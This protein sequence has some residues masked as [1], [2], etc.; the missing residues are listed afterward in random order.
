MAAGA[1]GT[2]DTVEPLPP[3][4]GYGDYSDASYFDLD[5]YA[6]THQTARCPLDAG[7][8][9]ELLPPGDGIAFLDTDPDRLGLAQE[10][11]AACRAGLNLSSQAP[12]TSEQAAIV[13]AYQL[14]CLRRPGK[15]RRSA[16]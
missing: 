9:I 12:P 15:A 10:T 4:T 8:D 7:F 5:H 6:A 11:A 13:S 14:D 3:T 2:G 1:R 16:R